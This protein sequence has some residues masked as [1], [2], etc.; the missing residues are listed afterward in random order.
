MNM[1]S[2]SR[3]TFPTRFATLRRRYRE[4]A[5]SWIAF[6]AL[7]AAWHVEARLD[8]QNAT[9]EDP[10]LAAKSAAPNSAAPIRIVRS[11]ARTWMDG[12]PKG[13]RTR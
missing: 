8:Q 7:L 11:E 6:G 12:V 2:I 10:R 1:V 4:A 13:L 5:V 9:N 3:Q